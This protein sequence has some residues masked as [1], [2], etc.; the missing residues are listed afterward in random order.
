MYSATEYGLARQATRPVQACRPE[1]LVDPHLIHDAMIAATRRCSGCPL[2]NPA[3]ARSTRPGVR[4]RGDLRRHQSL[5]TARGLPRRSE[6]TRGECGVNL[7]GDRGSRAG[8]SAVAHPRS[9][10]VAADR[11]LACFPEPLEI[12]RTRTANTFF[13]SRP[14]GPRGPTGASIPCPTAA[15]YRRDQLNKGGSAVAPRGARL[16]RRQWLN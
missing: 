16:V 15:R 12:A 4:L 11:F 14:R 3:R 2:S 9:F 6:A 13:V 10:I 5:G 7:G 1:P 8:E